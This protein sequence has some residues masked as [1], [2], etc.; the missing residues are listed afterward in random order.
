[1]H[2]SIRMRSRLP[3]RHQREFYCEDESGVCAG[4]FGGVSELNLAKG[5]TLRK[6]IPRFAKATINGHLREV[7]RRASRQDDGGEKDLE[8][9]FD[10]SLSPPPTH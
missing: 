10:D 4:E 1:M 9:S 8:M 7:A 3:E 6:V 2:E 5:S